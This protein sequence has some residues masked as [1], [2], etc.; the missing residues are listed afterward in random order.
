MNH[1]DFWKSK[2][3]SLHLLFVLSYLFTT[4]Q[5]IDHYHSWL[6]FHITLLAKVMD[7]I[8]YHLLSPYFTWYLLACLHS[9][10]MIFF[11]LY[12]YCLIISLVHFGGVCAPWDF[13]SCAIYFVYLLTL[14]IYVFRNHIHVCDPQTWISNLELFLMSSIP[15]HFLG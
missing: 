15:A 5:Q 2:P 10:K 11:L 6:S 12:N 9:K 3:G 14:K 4:V 13:I 1:I 8:F 7:F